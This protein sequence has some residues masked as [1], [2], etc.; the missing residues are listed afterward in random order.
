MECLLRSSYDRCYAVCRRMLGNQPDALDA[1]QDA[2]IAIVRGV[3]LFDGRSRYSTWAHRIAVNASIDEIRRRGRRRA[4]SLDEL[5]DH[6]GGDRSAHG[7]L[8]PE[9]VADSVDVDAA[10][11]GLPVEFRAA[12][13]LRDMCGMDYREV[14]EVLGV[15]VGTVKSRIARARSTLSVLLG[16]A[17]SER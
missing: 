4:V 8:G 9:A 17:R 13:V 5:S 11:M 12:V 3:G 7:A 6:A 15:P 16:P 14:A 10:L 1:A 2:M